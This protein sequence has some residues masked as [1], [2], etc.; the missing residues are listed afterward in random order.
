MAAAEVA[1]ATIDGPEPAE[2][3]QGPPVTLPRPGGW[4]GVGSRESGEIRLAGD[5]GIVQSIPNRDV[6]L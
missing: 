6:T 1:G 5:T 3:G 2:R 4:V